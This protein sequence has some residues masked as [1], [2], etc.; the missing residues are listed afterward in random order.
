MFVKTLLKSREVT[1]DKQKPVSPVK[2]AMLLITSRYKT[3]K[4][5]E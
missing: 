4:P 5:I 3:A 2:V 1:Y